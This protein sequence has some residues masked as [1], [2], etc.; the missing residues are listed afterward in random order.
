MKIKC[1]ECNFSHEILHWI[2]INETTEYSDDFKL[3]EVH[4]TCVCGNRLTIDK[5]ERPYHDDV[6][7]VLGAHELTP[8]KPADIIHDLETIE[9]LHNYGIYPYEWGITSDVVASELY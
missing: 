2:Q 3:Y 6:F 9:K 4:L 1:I 8:D 5:M 7:F